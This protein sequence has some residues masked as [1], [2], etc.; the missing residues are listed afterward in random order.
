VS[1]LLMPAI[2]LACVLGGTFF[3][4]VLRNRLPEII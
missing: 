3:G 1:P 4:M 2:A